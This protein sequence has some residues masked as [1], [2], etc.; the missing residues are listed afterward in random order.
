M[1]AARDIDGSFENAD[2]LLWQ[3]AA[4]RLPQY[5]SIRVRRSG[6]IGPLVEFAMARRIFPDAYNAVSFEPRFV[7]MVDQALDQGTITGNGV[8]DVAGIFPLAR[9]D[10]TSQDQSLWDQWAKHAEN[11]AATRNLP[12]RLV[13]GLLGALGELQDNVYAHSGRIETGLVAYAISDGAFEFVVADAGLG[14]LASLKQNSE[15]ANLE[16]SGQALRAALHDGASRFGRE[17]GHGYG[18][19]QL[20][21]ALAHERG[22]LRFRSGDYVLALSGNNLSLTGKMEIAKKAA[23]PGFVVSVLCRTSRPP[24]N[25]DRS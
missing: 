19:G 2:D 11:A 23:L 12:R 14:V 13:E 10:P 8:R 3:A 20:F 21:R 7:D 25:T 15:F 16:N 6:R 24:N 17:S 18:I 4:E 1:Q 5:G 22:D 9:H